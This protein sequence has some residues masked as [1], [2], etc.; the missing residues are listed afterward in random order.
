VR[1]IL[2]LAQRSRPDTSIPGVALTI[3]SLIVMPV[4][5][6]RKRRAARALDSRS[7]QADSVQTSVCVY[8]SAIVLVG[9]MLNALLGW[10]WADPIAA[11]A[12]AAL[13]AREGRALWTTEDFCCV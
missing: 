8:L 13:A 6:V 3:V 12:V 2:D 9:L 4:L 11:L 1:V 10:W 7:L 5:A